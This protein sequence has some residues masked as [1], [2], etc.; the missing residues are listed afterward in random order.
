MK[1]V[2]TAFISFLLVLNFLAANSS[3]ATTEVLYKTSYICRDQKGTQRWQ[4]DYELKRED[5]DT[6]IITEKGHGRYFGFKDKISWAAMTEFKGSGDTIRPLWL[7]KR[8]FNEDG[9]AIATQEQSFNY[10]NNVVTCTH[11]D[12]AKNTST[13]KKFTFKKDIVNR[14]LQGIYV[15]K[16]LENKEK[17]KEIQF[18]SPEPRLYNLQVKLLDTEE[19]EISGRKI[20]SY[21]IALDPMLGIFNFVKVFL[22][23][24]YVWHSARPEFE[25]LRYEG[26]ENSVSS[27]EVVI[28]T[29]DLPPRK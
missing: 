15:R 16:F 25:W 1:K 6:Y 13:K 9:K 26:V 28:T 10:D 17:C 11:E 27:P 2:C 8:I 20:K 23:K 4:A 3:Y 22:P 19:I 21:K 18:I 14:L 24:S 29:L 5:E 7:K 12:L